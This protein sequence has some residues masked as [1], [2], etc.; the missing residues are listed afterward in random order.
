MKLYSALSGQKMFFCALWLQ[1]LCLAPACSPTQGGS[2]PANTTSSRKELGQNNESFHARL[3]ALERLM[4]GKALPPDDL[5][6]KV[7]TE[8]TSQQARL[9]ALAQFTAEWQA[10]RLDLDTRLARLQNEQ[11]GVR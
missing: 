4:T 10:Y 6:G 8:Q 2:H 3:T 7:N 11:H 5:P 9:A 1:V